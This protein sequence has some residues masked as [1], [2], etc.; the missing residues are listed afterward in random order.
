VDLIGDKKKGP[1]RVYFTR[2][3]EIAGWDR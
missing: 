1:R 3:V 2:R